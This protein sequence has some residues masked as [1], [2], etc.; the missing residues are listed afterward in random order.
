MP[1]KR[2]RKLSKSEAMARFK[3]RDTRPEML[4]RRALWHRGL[5][6][7][8]HRRVADTRP[9]LVFVS[10]KLAIFVDGCFWHA[11]PLHGS[12]PATN[13]DFWRTKLLRN[14][15]RDAENTRTLM[16]AGWRVLRLWEHEI[17]EDAEAAADRVAESLGQSSIPSKRLG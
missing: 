12:Q 4:L 17:V 1:G 13:V 11:C 5:R 3:G 10:A 6:Y 2:R 16:A 8:L 9:D 7:R 15:Q 14:V